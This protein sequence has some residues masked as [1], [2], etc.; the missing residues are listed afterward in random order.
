[1]RQAV[2]EETIFDLSGQILHPMASATKIRWWHETHPEE[3]GRVAHYLC[4]GDFTVRRLGLLPVTDPSMAARTALYDISRGQWS[5]VMLEA[6]GIEV[7]QLAVIQPSGTPIGRIP[8]EQARLLGLGPDVTVVAGGHDQPC[9]ALGAG[10]VD[11][12]NVTY[13]LGTTE[14]LV[15]PLD[16][17]VSQL[18]AGGY[19]CYPHVVRNRF[20]TLAGNFTGGILLQWFRDTFA[21]KELRDAEETGRD[22]FATLIEEMAEVPTD[23]FVLPHF[24]TTGT[25]WNDP[26]SVG[27]I[28]GL[29]LDTTKGEFIRAL[30]EGVTYE[31]LLNVRHLATSGIP[32][33][34]YRA[35]GGGTQTRKVLQL[36]A[37]VLGKPI[38]VGQERE[39]ACRGAALLAAEGAGLISDAAMAAEGW[40]HG[41]R[42]IEPQEEATRFYAARFDVY[43]RLY[44]LMKALLHAGEEVGA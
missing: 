14:T 31:I 5:P 39:S 44:P 36:K 42:S 18:R 33:R 41:L 34:V 26:S 10:S 8:A 7:D 29:H 22:A 11:E 28:I 19:P 27:A 43:E 3:A 38:I 12:G 16:H 35:V 30:L 37:D 1:L 17:F 9:A 2:G 24:T 23:L 20:V 15:C 21:Q 40:Q 13:S 25:P 6:G 32:V 4:A